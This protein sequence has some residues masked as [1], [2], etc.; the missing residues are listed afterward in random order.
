M[1]VLFAGTPPVAL[2]SLEALLEAGF[3]VVGVI[4]RPPARRGRSSKL[5]DSPVAQYAKAKGL[6][7]LETSR[8]SEPESLRWIQDRQADLGVVVAYGALLRLDVLQSCRDGWV[9][10]HFSKLPDLRGA[11]PV[12][13]ALLRGD[14][15]AWTT[16]FYLDQGMDTGPVL[17]VEQ[18]PILPLETSGELLDRLAEIG[19][20]QL[21]ATLKEIDLGTATAHP[22]EESGELDVA[23]KLERKD[24]FVSFRNGA[25]ETVN[26]IRAV[27]PAPGAW[28]TDPAGKP[29]KVAQASFS[30]EILPAGSLRLNG[31]QLLVGTGTQ[32]IV[33][34]R[35]APAGKTWMNAAD[36]LRGARADAGARLGTEPEGPQV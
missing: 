16:V 19:A 35:V 14:K 34:G 30:S 23:R 18:T 12:Q 7:L 32:A 15:T 27:S 8:P 3:D 2:A 9:N 1:K 24:G 25:E 36:W 4:T 10:L 6:P 22:Q 29:L 33:L 26:R 11:A 20:R 5:V 21:V 17:S 28:T 31:Q 13:R